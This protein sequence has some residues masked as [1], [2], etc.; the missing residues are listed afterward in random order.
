MQRM[1]VT[2]AAGRSRLKQARAVSAFAELAH[3][4]G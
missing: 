4:F 3:P 1:G 2:L